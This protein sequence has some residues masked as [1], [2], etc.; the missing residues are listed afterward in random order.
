[1]IEI[2]LNVPLNL[3]S[4]RTKQSL[5]NAYQ[6]ANRY[7]PDQNASAE[8]VDLGLRSLSIPFWQAASIQNFR[9]STVKF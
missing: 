3:S 2:W 5:E 4:N 1:M 8:A 9:K 6:K 7:E